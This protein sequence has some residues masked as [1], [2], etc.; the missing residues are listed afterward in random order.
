M[1]RTLSIKNVS[2]HLYERL[3][4]RAAKHHRS[5]QGE[6]MAILEAGLIEDETLSPAALLSK[7]RES[8]LQ[9]P[10][11]SA[12]WVRQDRDDH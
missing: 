5:L 1:P 6:L 3:R 9:T 4:K 10:G 2:D 7:V 12:E 8:G 11:E